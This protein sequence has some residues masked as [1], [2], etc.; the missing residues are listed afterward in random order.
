MSSRFTPNSFQYNGR[1]AIALVPCLVV[2]CIV[3]GKPVLA[4]LSIG[5]MTSYIMDALQYREGAFTCAWL[6]LTFADIAFVYA[7]LTSSD[8]PVPLQV[9]MVFTMGAVAA[10]SG[11]WA[12]LQFKWIQ[13]QYPAVAIVFERNVITASLPVAA[14][15]HTLGLATMVEVSEIP[16]YLA[17]LLGALYYGCGRPLPSSFHGSKGA[18][19]PTIGGAKPR[20]EVFIQSKGD[21]FWMALVTVAVPP[22]LYVGIHWTVM[23]HLLHV[24]S[25]LLL[26]SVPLLFLGLLPRGMWWLPGGPRFARYCQ[27][28]LIALSL[29]AAL[30]GFEGRVVFYAFGQYIKLHPPWNWIAVTLALFGFALVSV[31][32]VL[33]ALGTVLDVTIAGSFL[34]LCTTAGA[35]AVGIPF[36]WL[37]APLVGACGLALFYDSHSLREYSVFVGGAFMTAVWFVYQHFWFLDIQVRRGREGGGGEGGAGGGRPFY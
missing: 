1:V 25:V 18:G 7:L 23:G 4:A 30:V 33:G 15:M 32:H 6:T 20:Q 36:H 17:V 31:A 19:G 29:F 35:L 16:Y 34:L 5:A 11:M 2:A 27:N 21:A 12:S 26:T 28:G 10:L 14:I 37:P 8:A 3:G 13:M 22:I 9:A 24:Y